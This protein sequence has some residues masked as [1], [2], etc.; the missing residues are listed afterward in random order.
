MNSLDAESEVGADAVEEAEVLGTYPVT[1]KI[2][3]RQSNKW[4]AKIKL[5]ECNTPFLI[6]T[7]AKCNVI[8]LACYQNLRRSWGVS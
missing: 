7:G 8:T 5:A 2:V 1:P 3:G 6:D 4:I